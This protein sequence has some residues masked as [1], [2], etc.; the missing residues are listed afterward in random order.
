MKGQHDPLAT[1]LR[2]K[3]ERES[4]RVCKGLV[5][6]V[7]WRTTLTLAG[8]RLGSDAGMRPVPAACVKSRKPTAKPLTLGPEK[9]RSGVCDRHPSG[10][11]W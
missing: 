2:Q 7:E 6:D 5:S 1:A 3:F 10:S 9:T 8:L 11:G 4:C